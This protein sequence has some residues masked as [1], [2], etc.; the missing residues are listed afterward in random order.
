[1]E[2]LKVQLDSAGATGDDVIY[3]RSSVLD[4]DEHLKIRMEPDVFG[5]ENAEELPT[6]TTV[7][8]A[9]GCSPEFLIEIDRM[10]IVGTWSTACL[11]PPGLLAHRPQ[12]C[13]RLPRVQSLR[14]KGSG[15]LAG[16][17]G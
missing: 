11:A 3:R 7:G 8:S 10:A 9:R 12:R 4:V 6:S 13:A 16:C 14:R 2:N 5:M 1:M 17:N 15:R